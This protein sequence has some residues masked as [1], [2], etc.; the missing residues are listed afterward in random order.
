MEI[1]DGSFCF[2]NIR[3]DFNLIEG[4]SIWFVLF[5]GDGQGRGH[6]TL[7]L[8]FTRRQ[9]LN[10]PKSEGWVL[11]FLIIWLWDLSSAGL[12]WHLNS[13]KRNFG[14]SMSPQWSSAKQWSSEEYG[15]SSRFIIPS[16]HAIIYDV[17]VPLGGW[18]GGTLSVSRL[19]SITETEW[20][21]WPPKIRTFANC[22]ALNGDGLW[23][24]KSAR[25]FFYH[26]QG[27]KQ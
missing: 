18:F 19:H 23:Y 6:Q 5:F 2:S 1:I 8:T 25:S 15:E 13:V 12:L 17:T 24:K 22:R 26:S 4:F 16:E 11:I 27:F 20:G 14:T 21:S 10:E 7:L 9:F 3:W